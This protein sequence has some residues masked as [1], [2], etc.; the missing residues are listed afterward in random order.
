[1]FPYGSPQPKEIWSLILADWYSNPYFK[2]SFFVFE[3]KNN[4]K[5]FYN[6][7]KIFGPS[8]SSIEKHRREHIFLVRKNISIFHISSI[9]CFCFVLHPQNNPLEYVC[10]CFRYRM[11]FKTFSNVSYTVFYSWAKHIVDY[12]VQCPLLNWISRF[13]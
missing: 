11:K 3:I 1:M 4:K 12:R 8:N 6:S 5:K 13:L 7:E 2:P 10:S 9:S